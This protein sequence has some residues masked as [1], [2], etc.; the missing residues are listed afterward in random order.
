MV[1]IAK[2]ALPL[3][4]M[5][6]LQGCAT[7]ISPQGRSQVTYQGSFGALQ[8]NPG[9]YQGQ[10]ALLGGKILEVKATPS[11]SELVVL[12]FPLASGDRPE[13]ADQSQGRFLV[14]S[15]KFLDPAVY[16]KD[17]KVTVL[18]QITGSESRPIGGFNYLYP[19]LQAREIKVW[20]PGQR[21]PVIFGIG[22]GTWIH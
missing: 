14:R 4:L 15:D 11:L 20:Q 2:A 19:V 18:G 5:A 13:D 16:Q 7:G 12:Q 21:F 8:S 1:K 3:L 10:T 17:L 9:A 22:I 6:Y